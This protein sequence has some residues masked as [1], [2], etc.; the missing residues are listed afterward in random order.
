MTRTPT[1]IEAAVAI[2]AETSVEPDYRDPVH[3]MSQLVDPGSLEPVH[4]RPGTGVVVARGRI[5]G[6]EVVGYATDG[7]RGGG[8]LGTDE[9]RLIAEAIDSAAARRCPVI[10]IWPSAGATGPA[11]PDAAGQADPG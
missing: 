2:A 8:T 7:S 3:R 1:P 5:D 6:S 10:G 9:C 4:R 11:Q